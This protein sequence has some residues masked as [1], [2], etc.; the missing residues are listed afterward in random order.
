MKFKLDEYE[1]RL[2]I[3]VLYQQRYD[4]DPQTNNEIDDF[5][6]QLVRTSKNMK[7]CCREKFRFKPHRGQFHLDVIN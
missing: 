2:L 5:L 1:I 7:P 4:Y 6:L 3:N